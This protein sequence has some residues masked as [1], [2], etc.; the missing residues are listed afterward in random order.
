VVSQALD[1]V[2]MLARRNRQVRPVAGRRFAPVASGVNFIGY[3]HLDAGLGTAARRNLKVLQQLAPVIEFP[4]P[5]TDHIVG[6]PYTVNFHHWHPE[7]SIVAAI[8]K[9][10]VDVF[11]GR[12]NIGFWVM[13][14][15]SVPASWIENS[16]RFDEVWTASEFCRRVLE[17]S[18]A[19]C[20][21]KVLPHML[22]TMTRPDRERRDRLDGFTFVVAYDSRSRISRKNPFA[23]ITAFLAAFP[24]EE[25]V[26]LVVKVRHPQPGEEQ[27]LLAAAEGDSRV[28][29]IGQELS[30]PEMDDLW[31]SAHSYVS[32]HRS[33]GFGLN[34]A[35][36]MASGLYCIVTGASGCL[37]FATPDRVKWVAASETQTADAYFPAGGCWWEPDEGHATNLMREAWETYGDPQTGAMLEAAATVS[38]DLSEK[39]VAERARSMLSSIL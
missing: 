34:V 33:E 17:R 1:I 27:L 29:I 14:T 8:N 36:A 37:D 20:P 25:P 5:G 31:R 19:R 15:T 3:T 32:L 12:Y 4:F 18:G 10:P 24:A 38:A 16:A 6:N 39:T 22:P 23:A 9:N 35:E 13:E 21:V 26:R 28:S 30:R 7:D 11:S 2:L